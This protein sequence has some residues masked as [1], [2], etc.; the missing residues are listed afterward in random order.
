MLTVKD[1]LLSEGPKVFYKESFR[2]LLEE[3]LSYLKDESTVEEVVIEPNL[4]NKFKHNFY[5][6]LNVKNI[7]RQYHWIVMRMNNMHSSSDFNTT[8]RTFIMPDINTIENMVK[9]FNVKTKS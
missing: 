5:G 2:N 9:I 1:H 4:L 3:H 6:Y 7:P 8:M